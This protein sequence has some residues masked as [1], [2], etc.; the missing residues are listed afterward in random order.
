MSGFRQP[1]LPRE[2]LLL[3]AK[4]LD[5][6]VAFDHPVRLF[7]ALLKSEAF[8]ET[9]NTWEQEYH[10][11]EGQPPY[12]PRDLAGL[13]IYG[14]LN[15]IR[16]SRSLE[17]VCHNRIDFIW[18]L[19]NQRPDHATIAGFV[20]RNAKRLRAL[21]KDALK[22]SM[23]AG[24][25]TLDHVAYDGTM[26]A[27]DAG[28]SSIRSKESIAAQLAALDTE[29]QACETEWQAN[30]KRD[31]TLL[32]G[33]AP[34][35]PDAGTMPVKLAAL[36][37]K[38]E[39]LQEALKNIQRRQDESTHSTKPKAISSIVDP[40]SRVMPSKEGGS[41]PNYNAQLGV[42]AKSGIIVAA[43]V[44]DKAE[45]G[46]CLTP[47][48]ESTQEL[49]GK[50]P[51]EVSADGSYNTGPNLSRLEAMSVVGYLPINGGKAKSTAQCVD[52]TKELSDAE[53]AALPK[54]KKGHLTKDAFVY[55]SA[56]DV[57]RCPM[58][59]SLIFTTTDRDRKNWGERVRR[60]YVCRTCKL[61]PRAKECCS[62]PPRGRT[63]KRDQYEAHRERLKARMN[64]PEAQSRYGLRKQTVE[65][66]FGYIKHVLGIRRFLRRG[67]ESVKAEWMGICTT[68]NF[69]VLLK[70]WAVV[71]AVLKTKC[72]AK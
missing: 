40:D 4:Q 47:M 39:R 44:T 55:D 34:W 58:G 24:L 64:T 56:Q 36:K 25:A 27:A 49:S 26:V 41:R 16:S 66:R 13:Y 6:A 42:D 30:E 63:L 31:Y 57:Y 7:D 61:C 19:S 68:V 43:D 8:S 59:Q 45:D 3:W 50:L 23:D 5:D 51:R 46:S 21:F 70:K 20:A 38:Q 14:M 32:A 33:E 28:K 37:R 67:M 71:K 60:T 69:A 29:V 62:N 65:P 52:A 35:T 22:V 15:R 53:W 12:H 1:E 72:R 17:M 18:L 9:F 10:L 48:L 54:D 11:R 2:Q